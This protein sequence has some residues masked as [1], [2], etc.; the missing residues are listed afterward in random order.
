MK[1]KLEQKGRPLSGE[2]IEKEGS[3]L[4]KIMQKN[5]LIG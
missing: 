4:R 2:L 3:S 1:K 5:Y